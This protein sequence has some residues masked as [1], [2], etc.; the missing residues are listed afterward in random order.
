MDGGERLVVAGLEAQVE[1]LESAPPQLSKLLDVLGEQVAGVGVAAHALQVGQ[2]A[3]QEVEDVAELARAERERVAVGEEHAL[4][5]LPHGRGE[6]GDVV[7]DLR[8]GSHGER[9]VEVSPAEV[10]G[11]VGAAVRDLDDQ[12]RS[13]ARGSDDGAVI[14]H[15]LMLARAVAGRA[16]GLRSRVSGLGLSGS[17]L[18]YSRGAAHEGGGPTPS[19][20]SHASPGPRNAM[21]N[22]G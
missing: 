13:L 15:G 21:P 3:A 5:A 12:A 8:E 4:D 9:L 20:R 6:R 19:L 16:G 2:R 7:D 22:R 17:R 11:V 14:P 10:T 18:V 1:Q